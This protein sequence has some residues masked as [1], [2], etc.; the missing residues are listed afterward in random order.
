MR[1]FDKQD[2]KLSFA[3]FSKTT[4]ILCSLFKKKNGLEQQ[5]DE[6]LTDSEQ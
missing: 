2:L 6:D 1:V 3:V 4:V 5:R